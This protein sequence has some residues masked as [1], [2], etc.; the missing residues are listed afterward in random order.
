MVETR[1]TQ[2]ERSATTRKMLIDAAVDSLVEHGWAATTTVEVCRRTGLTRG[3]VVHHFP[4]LPSLL[5][6]A[7]DAVYDDLIRTA[8]RE[9]ATLADAIDATWACVGDRRFKAV[10]ESWLA[11]ANDRDLAREIGPVVANF[12]KLVSP[13]GALRDLTLNADARLFYLT[14]RETMLG[15]A[16]GRALSAGRALPHETVVLDDLRSRAAELDGRPRS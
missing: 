13:D 11:A 6:S 8:V 4:S 12:A 3:A 10:I 5:A 15:L 2:V 1:R 16:L 9:P 14:A 7:L